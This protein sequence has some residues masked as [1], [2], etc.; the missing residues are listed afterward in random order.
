[1]LRLRLMVERGSHLRPQASKGEA[2][3][4]FH[5]TIPEAA[6]PW[7]PL[8]IAGVAVL[9]I[10]KA[11]DLIV[12]DRH[13]RRRVAAERDRRRLVNLY[14]P[15]A[16]L[17]L[18]RH[19][20]ASTGTNAP[21]LRH[22]VEN[23]WVELGSYRRRTVAVKRAFRALFDRQ[24]STSAEVEFGGDFPLAEIAKLT[25]RHAEHTD[26]ALI[27]FVRRADRSRYEEPGS[28]LLTDA[29]FE[30]FEHI[31]AE[32]DRLSRKFG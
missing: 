16:T 15:L 19:L 11:A 17:F 9:A 12:S 22:R 10:C 23:A 24:S 27:E 13:Q 31:T 30:L 28:G 21:R 26:A 1:V 5:I 8:A 25:R 2:Q 7:F 3:H 4:V 6:R 32:H 20:T 14:R 18:T 29:E